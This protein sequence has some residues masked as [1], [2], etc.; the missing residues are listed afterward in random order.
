MK[1]KYDVIIVGSGAGGG[2]AARV[3]TQR[4]KRVLL[5]EKGQWKKAEDFL[6]YDELHFL[7]HKALTP[8]LA[9]D[10]NVY[11]DPGG[12]RTLV[13]RWWIGNMVGGST[14]LWEANLP[15]YTDEDFAVIKYLKD[16]P[17]DTSMVN[18]P[19]RYDEWHPY[20]ER[21][22]WEWGVS[23]RARQCA[24][25]EPTR[26]GYE[27][28]MGPLRPHASTPFLMRA[29]AK[30]KM[31]PYLSPRGINTRTYDGRPGCPF[32]GYC[33]SFGCAVNDRASSVNTVLARALRTGRCEL[34][35]GCCVTRLLHEKGRVV[36]VA[37]K[38]EPNGAE[39]VIKA[40][41]VLVSIQAIESARLFLYSEVPD[42]NKMV[43]RYLTYH[44]KGSAE[45]TFK[46]QPVWD[47]GPD[48]Q[49][50]PRTSLGSLQLRDL[51][52][53]K[54]PESPGLS[55][56][57]K[58]SI[59]DPFTI[60]PLIR[61]VTRSGY[62][63]KKGRDLWGKDL[64]DRL[65]ELR[66]QG[67]VSFSFTGET[68]SVASNR[69]ELD[70]DIK[71]PWGTPAAR[72]YYKH[73]DYDIKLSEYALKKVCQVMADNGGEV[74]KLEPQKAENE[75][76]GHNHGTLRAGADPGASVLDTDCQSH[77]VKGLYVLDCAFMPT[78]GASNPTLTL[79]A[80]AYRVCERI[81]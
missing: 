11:I 34:R 68:M 52:V 36:G 17:P 55:K 14:M 40:P 48:R 2:T 49:F 18:W 47:E 65:A 8:P 51:Y 67:G 56:G 78:A 13:D 22:E 25:Q 50:Q 79:I 64:V 10:P 62:L 31:T 58:F 28:P 80:N 26:P 61:T 12:K 42:P 24:A 72:V 59:Y 70:P 6:P 57:G 39:Q 54:D 29:F 19:W 37:C 41:L 32:C 46:G 3:M 43:G 4:G 81:A 23:G 5:L 33:Q 1:D 66:T 30:A 77:T 35:T 60:T 75:G 16:P 21:A 73:H 20:F 74:R 71:D 69:V 45:L 76:Y 53:I 27:Y 9:T 15:R 38:T 63:P 44:T 7:D